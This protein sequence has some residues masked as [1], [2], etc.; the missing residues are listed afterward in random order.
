MIP[1]K[2]PFIYNPVAGLRGRK[3]A[4]KALRYLEKRDIE[5][6]VLETSGKDSATMLAQAVAAEGWPR[7]V[8]AGGDGT[9]NEAINGIAGTAAE[10]AIIPTGTANVLAKELG[11][12]DDLKHACAIAVEGE[13]RSVDLGLAGERYFALMAGI[14]F[15]AMVIKN[16]NP[17]LKKAVRHAAYPVA[18]LKT[19][20]NEELPLLKVITGEHS[21]KGFFIVVANSH[22][23]GGRFGPAPEASMTDGLLDVCVLKEKS[24]A[25]MIEFWYKALKTEKVAG[26]WVEYFRTAELEIAAPSGETVLVQVDGE[27]VSELPVRVNIEHHALNVLVETER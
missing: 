27:V 12:P 24:F 8:V 14:G 7:I 18:G 13:S 23:Y 20:V 15:D 6:V 17:V 9:L 2:L 16:V 22:Y 5:I 26:P 10:L 4:E 25:K 3:K 21:I 19:F 1:A 11:I